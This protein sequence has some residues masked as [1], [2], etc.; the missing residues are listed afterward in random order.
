MIEQFELLHK[1]TTVEKSKTRTV[2]KTS[3]WPT[4]SLCLFASS[5]SVRVQELTPRA[6]LMF[7][8]LCQ[9]RR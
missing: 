5:V 4:Y 9:E 1:N 7:K 8:L 6:K 2:G 3:N